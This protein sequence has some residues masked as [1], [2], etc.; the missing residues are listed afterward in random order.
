[1]A[2]GL[3]LWYAKGLAFSCHGC[4]DCCRGE[5]YVW[6]DEAEVERLAGFLSLDSTEFPRRY[7]R[8]V[9]GRLSLIDNAEGDC[10]FLDGGCSVYE[11]RPTQCRTFPFWQENIAYEGAWAAVCLKC[12]GAGA[13]ELY[14][15]ERIRR[16]SGRDGATETGP[17]GGC[18]ED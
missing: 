13:G 2:P 6:L 7:L 10:I 1:M 5:G 14:P 18:S 12:R 4:S 15:L 16:L 8:R 9:D 17:G 3:D 11:A